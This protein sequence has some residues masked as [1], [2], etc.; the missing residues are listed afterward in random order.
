MLNSSQEPSQSCFT[1]PLFLKD[2]ASWKIKLIEL[3]HARK[4]DFDF[5]EIEKIILKHLYDNP[6]LQEL[7]SKETAPKSTWGFIDS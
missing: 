7:I 4:F 5:T 2:K 3:F 1:T 6:K